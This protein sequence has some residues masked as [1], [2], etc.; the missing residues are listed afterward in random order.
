M[1]TLETNGSR[2][3]LDKNLYCCRL[4]RETG[5]LCV[6]IDSLNVCA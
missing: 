6:V 1:E 5:S 3:A 4:A 2:S